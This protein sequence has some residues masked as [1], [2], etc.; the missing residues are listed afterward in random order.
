MSAEINP[1]YEFGNFRLDAREKILLCDEKPLAVTPKVFETLQIFVEN[2]GRLLAKDELIQ[3]LWQDRFVEESNLTFNIKMLRK[4]LQDNPRSPRFIETVPRRGY[5]FIAEV[6]ENSGGARRLEQKAEGVDL[7]SPAPAVSRAVEA[8]PHHS[9]LSIA[10]VSILVAS[11]VLFGFWMTRDATIASTRAA[12][13]LSKQFRSEKISNSGRTHAV[14]TPDGKYVAYTNESGGRESIWLRQL[15]TGENIQIVPPSDGPYLGM[16]I[17]H[18]GNSLYFVRRQNAADR[19]SS[20]IYRVMTFGGI[21]AKIAEKTE[22]WISLSPDDKQI[23]FVRCNYQEGDFCSLFAINSDG[24][25]ERE[26]LRRKK[27]FTISDNQFSPDGKSIA[28][29]SGQ[30]WSGGS[31]YRLMSIDLFSGTEKPV[32]AKSFFEIRNLKWLPDGSGLLISALENLDHRMKIWQ[33]D[34]GSGAAQPLTKDATDYISLSLDRAAD[35]LVAITVAN[36]FRLFIAGVD[37][38]LQPRNLMPA[39]KGVA[40]GPDGRIVYAG[41]D[42]NIW[43]INRDGGEQRQLTNGPSSEMVPKFSPDGQLIFFSSNRSGTNQIWRMNADGSNQTQL[44]KRE[45]GYPKFV[46]P[47]GAFLYYESCLHQTLWRVA[48]DGSSEETRVSESPMRLPAFSPDGKLVAYSF[49]P[50]GISEQTNLAVMDLES[51]R[52]IKT[53]NLPAEITRLVRIAWGDNQSFY[54]TSTCRD[55]NPLWKQS[56][57]SPSASLVGDLGPEELEDFAISPDGKEF[58]FIRGKWLHDAVLIE[59]LR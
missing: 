33:I 39:R 53:F 34:T 12:P 57:A 2:P 54:Y 7:V 21:P 52:I 59:G 17:S 23:S 37:D 38:L 46:T 47:D 3:K 56:L 55:R 35:K 26:L 50:A 41:D 29:A 43:M 20:T 51:R 58:A 40:L 8:R 30:S 42:G 10:A 18:D 22:G 45:G 24:S 31:D 48:T 25:G 44:S 14:V 32:S 13:I 11:A 49:H 16:A 28:F 1:I 6:R 27:P 4:A 15:E 19:T 36:T 9:Y 5:R